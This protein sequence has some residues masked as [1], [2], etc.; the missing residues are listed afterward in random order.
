MSAGDDAADD[1]A[2]PAVV[3]APGAGP[4][5]DARDGERPE[6]GYYLYGVYRAGAWRGSGATQ[7]REDLLRIRYSDLEALVRTVPFAIP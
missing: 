5:R 1:A 2:A 6:A 7:E 4:R 3:P